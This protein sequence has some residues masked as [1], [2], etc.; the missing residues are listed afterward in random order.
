VSQML[1]ILEKNAE[2]LSRRRFVKSALALSAA[3]VAWAAGVREA[4]AAN[5]TGNP[6]H[7]NPYGSCSPNCGSLHAWACCCLK[8]APGS[9]P[10]DHCTCPNCA[11]TNTWAW[12]CVSC[13][14]KLW[15]CMECN[16]GSCSAAWYQGFAP[17]RAPA[18]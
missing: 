7:N 13:S 2:A 15:E 16:C 6:I 17:G 5:C 10:S 11:E 9:C 4:F 3:S 1:E 18:A 12:Y 14:N 8:W